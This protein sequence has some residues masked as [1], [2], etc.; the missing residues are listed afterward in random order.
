[1]AAAGVHM[2]IGFVRGDEHDPP[3]GVHVVPLAEEESLADV[4]IRAANGCAVT[5]GAAYHAAHQVAAA[6]TQPL[7]PADAAIRLSAREF[8]W[9]HPERRP[10]TRPGCATDA[11]TTPAGDRIIVSSTRLNHP[12]S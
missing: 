6:L 4:P 2:V 5:T 11:G 10:G 7:G 1:M 8:L 9:S 3:P 12:V